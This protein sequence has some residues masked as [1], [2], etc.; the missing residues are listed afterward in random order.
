[1]GHGSISHN[2]DVGLDGFGAGALVGYLTNFFA[3]KSI[4]EPVEPIYIGPLK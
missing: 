1:M 2:C 4:F 3:I